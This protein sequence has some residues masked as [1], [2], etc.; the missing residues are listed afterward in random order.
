MK[1]KFMSLAIIFTIIAFIGLIPKNLSAKDS[2][3]A[4]L[5]MAVW[6]FSYLDQD[7]RSMCRY[8]KKRPLCSGQRFPW[9]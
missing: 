5:K 9:Y 8:V 4:A 1:N 2:E 3:Q 7:S 6:G